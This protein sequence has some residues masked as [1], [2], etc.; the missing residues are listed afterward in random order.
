MFVRFL[1]PADPPDLPVPLPVLLLLTSISLGT[2]EQLRGA[3]WVAGTGAD[4]TETATRLQFEDGGGTVTVIVGN[5][6]VFTESSGDASSFASWE[7]AV[8]QFD[9]EVL[10][11][12][13]N[14]DASA[15][16]LAGGDV[17]PTALMRSG[18]GTF[19]RIASEAQD[20]DN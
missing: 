12:V 17:D 19:A 11:I 15:S 18:H 3:G 9:G 6:P 1:L 5:K 13:T 4:F 16:L 14:L 2:A 20:A 10:L 7:S 8:T